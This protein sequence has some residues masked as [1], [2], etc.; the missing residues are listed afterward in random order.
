MVALNRSSWARNAWSTCQTTLY[1]SLSFN[2]TSGAIP[3]GTPIG[4]DDVA[5]VLARRLAHH[6]AHG[7]DHIDHGAARR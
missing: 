4:K 6:P 7:L 1:F 2:A 5:H 3:A